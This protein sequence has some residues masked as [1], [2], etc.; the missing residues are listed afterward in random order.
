MEKV[1][2]DKRAAIIRATLELV[3]ERG[4]HGAPA[5]AIAERAGVGIGTIYRY[6]ENKDVLIMAVMKDFEDRVAEE[7][8]K[9]GYMA[10]GPVKE[11]FTQ[12]VRGILHYNIRHPRE[13][14]FIEQ[15]M[16]S[17]YGAKCR[18]DK[19]YSELEPEGIAGAFIS[20]FADGISLGEVKDLPLPVLHAITFG[21]VTLAIRDH[22]LGLVKMD[23]KLIDATVKACWDAVSVRRDN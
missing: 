5:A 11:R 12:L 1:K 9:K 3:A 18:S 15:F 16:N 14:K 23:E 10:D 7:L 8:L 6:F 19:M 21:P 2:K 13:F 22:I 20:M 17:P 4:F